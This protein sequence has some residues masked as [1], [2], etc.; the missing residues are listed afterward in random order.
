MPRTRTALRTAAIGATG[1]M[2]A[3]F[4]GTATPASAVTPVGAT[5][6][7]VTAWP[8]TGGSTVFGNGS[9][10]CTT[11]YSGSITITNQLRKYANGKWS[12]VGE[13]VSKQFWGG[14]GVGDG[15]SIPCG[16]FGTQSQFKTLTTAK[17]DGATASDASGAAGYS[18]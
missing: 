4:L 14:T 8:P 2:A 17:V 18:C 10:T 6:C 16:I 9:V 3:A 11:W 7:N 15:A 13:P 12:S 1:T 5:G